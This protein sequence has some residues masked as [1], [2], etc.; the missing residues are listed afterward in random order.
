[1][2]HMRKL[3]FALVLLG[4]MTFSGCALNKMMKAAQQQE[5]TVTPNPLE[6][7]ADSVA[8]DISAKLPVKMLKE[9]ITYTLNPYYTYGDQEL[10]LD[11]ITFKKADY[12]SSDTQQPTVSKHYSFA[13]Q[14]G[15]NPGKL[16]VKG[17]A[18]IEKNGKSKETDRM[19]I[20]D[21]VITTSEMAMPAYFA[22][23]ADH[24]YNN[25]EELIP[26]HVNFYFQQGRSYL[27]PSE[28]RS[29]R[30]KK[31]NA[32]I[33]EKNV[34]RSVTITGTHSPEG[35]ERINSHLSEDRAQVIEKYYKRQMRKYDYKGM[36][37]SI[38]FIL[39][40]IVDDWTDFKNKLADYDGITD[41]QKQAYMDIVNG[42]GTFEEKEDMMHKLDTYKKVFKD[43]Y[44]DL[45]AAKTEVLTVKEKKSDAEISVLAKQ[46]TEGKASADTLSME[47]LLYSATLTPSLDE[48]Q[49]IYEAATKKNGGN[50]VAHNNLGAVYLAKAMKAEGS[51]MSDNAKKAITEFQLSVKQKEN[52]AAYANMASALFMQGNVE[53]ALDA[54]N[55]AK[56][57]GLSS[58]NEQGLNGVIGALDLKVAKYDDAVM[59]LAKSDENATNLFNRGLALLLNEKYQNADNAFDES[60]A[61]EKMAETYYAKAIANAHLGN[62]AKVIENISEAVKMNPDLK[63]KALND[64]EFKSYAANDAFRNALK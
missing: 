41:D 16:E 10:S 6:E 61:K 8:F 26:T 24:G 7:H 43:I 22:A 44:P 37:D 62:D 32:F 5:L 17:V 60:L 20:A 42:S 9:G 49:A 64:L 50:A 27:R 59:A 53:K 46:I 2:N 28:I 12:P 14:N 33:A 45:R 13:Y 40:P 36:A 56:S 34:T 21:G 39:K 4:S 54:A 51:M 58:E 19:P 57:M 11:P 52:A 1:M 29:D 15:M 47:E 30:G 31:L 48:K 18:T 25:K 63:A 38:K 55:K 35:P 3:I 23:Y